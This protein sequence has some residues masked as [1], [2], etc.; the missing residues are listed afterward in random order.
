MIDQ[1]AIAYDRIEKCIA[2]RRFTYSVQDVIDDYGE[3]YLRGYYC[4][5]SMSIV[6]QEHKPEINMLYRYGVKNGMYSNRRISL[7]S[8]LYY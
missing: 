4:C 7:G 8:W 3:R 6:I 5:Y 2:K 1:L